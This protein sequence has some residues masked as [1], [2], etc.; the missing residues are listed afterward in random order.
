MN[1][2]NLAEIRE[3]VIHGDRAAALSTLRAAINQ[4]KIVARDGVELMLAV[5][6]GS[7]EAVSDAVEAMKW[8]LPCVYRFV[9]KTD[10]AVN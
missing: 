8:G 2:F 1:A 4:K 10:H 7:P 6:Q 5:R 3:C 9:P